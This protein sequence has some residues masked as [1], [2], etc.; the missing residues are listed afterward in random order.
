MSFIVLVLLIRRRVISKFS[1]SYPNFI[2]I[3][4]LFGFDFTGNET[5]NKYR[6]YYADERKPDGGA[7][8]GAID[9]DAHAKH[10]VELAEGKTQ[11]PWQQTFV[12]GV[13]YKAFVE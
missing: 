11:G 8:Y 9:G 7:A 10:Y 2:H 6:F 5:D 13:G 1:H 3:F 12:K 4:L